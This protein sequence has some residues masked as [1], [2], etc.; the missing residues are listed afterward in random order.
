[1]ILDIFNNDAFKLDSMLAALENVETVPNGLG[2]MN[3]FTPN[4]VRTESVSIESRDNGLS[5]IQTSQRGAP[6]E[7]RGGDSRSLR[8]FNT[9]RIIK[10]DRVLASELAFIREFGEEQMLIEATREVAR[11]MDGPSGILQEIQMTKEHM[12]LG[13]IQG[14]VLDADGSEIINW[15]DEFGLTPNTPINFGLATAN[16]GDIRTLCSQILRSTIRAS[17]G[18]WTNSS[19]LVA[20]CG[21]GFFDELVKTEEVRQKYL[22]N[23][24]SQYVEGGG[25]FESI[26]YGNIEFINYQGTDDNST[27]AIPS[28]G[29][30]FFPTNTPG[31]FLDVLS[32]GE[33]FESLGTLGQ[34]YYPMIVRDLQRNQFIDIEVGAYTLQVCTKPNMLNSGVAN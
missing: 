31:A 14:I 4:P 18:T 13:A 32:P 27:I 26:V 2:A 6:I 23:T 21:D 22:N 34:E 29:V 1:M 15:F 28:N 9:S 11:R 20:L 3:I 16:L 10:G 17:K 24:N 5:L 30:K 8:Q 19:R 12:R 7:Q 25:A 33:S